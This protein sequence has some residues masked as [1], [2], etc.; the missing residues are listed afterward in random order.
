MK[1]FLQFPVLLIFF[2]SM[3]SYSQTPDWIWARSAQSVNNGYGEGLNIV[4]DQYENIYIT[5]YHIDTI[6]F[7][8]HI[9]TGGG[10]TVFLA[11]YDSSG[12]IKWAKGDSCNIVLN[13]CRSYGIC[14]DASFNCYITGF[15]Y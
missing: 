4:T 7:S 2:F 9:L 8:N 11:K 3:K 6:K 12:H 13:S 1:T 10:E 15:F 14:T 5:G